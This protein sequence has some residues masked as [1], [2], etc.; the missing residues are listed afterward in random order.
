MCCGCILLGKFQR[1]SLTI[2]QVLKNMSNPDEIKS[3]GRRP[4]YRSWL[5]PTIRHPDPPEPPPGLGM[6]DLICWHIREYLRPK[7]KQE[8][9]LIWLA[10]K[11]RD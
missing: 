5:G 3:N 10:R 1:K 11:Q 4:D 6:L 7:S 8:R 9:L 2:L